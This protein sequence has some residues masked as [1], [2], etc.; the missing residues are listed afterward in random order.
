MSPYTPR[1]VDI[2]W[3]RRMMRL[4]RDGG[5][6]SYPSTGLVYRVDHAAKTLTLLNPDMLMHFESFVVHEQTKTVFDLI[7]YEVGEIE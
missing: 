5:I 4:I 1:D 6:L 3:A 2:A 7:G